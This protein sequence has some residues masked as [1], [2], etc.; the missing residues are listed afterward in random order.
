MT[1][2][3]R[4]QDAFNAYLRF[5]ESKGASAENLAQR[6][7]LLMKL[8][9]L[10]EHQP[11]DG[12]AFRDQI[13]CVLDLLDRTAWPAFLTVAR[14]YYYFWASDIKAIAAMHSGGGYDIANL[15][16]HVPL[17]DL[18]TLWKSIDQEKF[19]LAETWPLKAYA[20]ALRDEGA[21]KSVVETRSK[22]V[23]LLLVRLRGASA[24]EAGLYRKAVDSTLP[25]F[26]MK[27]MRLL[28][29]IVVQEFY[30]FWI[31]DPEAASHLVLDAQQEET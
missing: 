4:E 14:E 5:L 18:R 25:L 23:K 16:D 8:L 30:Y 15:H 29:Q 28:F 21:E 13:E 19:E 26:A 7:T 20:S 22:L 3:N 2:N 17:E 1:K 6:R 27:E 12:N 10:L 24:K 9:P 11:M 31:G